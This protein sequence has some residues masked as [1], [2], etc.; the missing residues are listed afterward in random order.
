MNFN[1][2]VTIVAIVH[3]QSTIGD[4]L[5]WLI[6]FYVWWTIK[7]TNGC[8]KS[9]K[10]NLIKKVAASHPY[11]IL[12]Q[13]F[14]AEFHG[15]LMTSVTVMAPFMLFEKKNNINHLFRFIGV[16]ANV[17]QLDHVQTPT[18]MHNGIALKSIIIL[19]KSHH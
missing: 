10:W 2:L 17:T 7:F 14:H 5:Q 16:A 8:K 15:H 11:E 9:E 6:L 13:V 19:I 3:R 1:D 4:T 12:N 18:L